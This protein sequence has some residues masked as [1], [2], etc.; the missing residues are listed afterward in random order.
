MPGGS[1][2]VRAIIATEGERNRYESN[3]REPWGS[4]TAL[5]HECC[6]S[7]GSDLRRL[8]IILT[9]GHEYC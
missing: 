4:P 8:S 5:S 1:A 3:A 7:L 9:A 6:E 2:P